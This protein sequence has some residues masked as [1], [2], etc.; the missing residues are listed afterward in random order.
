[1]FINEIISGEAKKEEIKE[2]TSQESNW[3]VTNSSG[4]QLLMI[5]SI[6]TQTQ[7]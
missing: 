1:M 3:K 7:Q 6:G 4:N 2:K 5:E